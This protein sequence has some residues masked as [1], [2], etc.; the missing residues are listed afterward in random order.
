MSG[1]THP[2]L[3]SSTESVGPPSVTRDDVHR[4]T[5]TTSNGGGAAASNG[6]VDM[7][8]E[9]MPDL[10]SPH[11]SP[12]SD[13]ILDPSKFIDDSY[14]SIQ[15]SSRRL[16][17]DTRGYSI[18]LMI[19]LNFLSSASFSIVLPSMWSYLTVQFNQSIS[20]VGWAVC[21]NSLG[22]FL[23]SPLMSFWYERR[24]A[25]E[26]LAFSLAAMMLG[27]VMYAVAGNPAVILVSRALVG[28]SSA[29][30]TIV[31]N[32]LFLAT[33]SSDR[34][35]IM[36]YNSAAN[37]LGFTFGPILA[38]TL[39]LLP[40]ITLAPGAEIN[41][42]TNPGYCIAILSTIALVLVLA[43]LRE[44]PKSLRKALS[45]MIRDSPPN[46]D[47]SVHRRPLTD[48][49]LYNGS[50]YFGTGGSI[51]D[52][53]SLSKAGR[54]C[55]IP[56]LLCLFFYYAL[57]SAFTVWE[58]LGASFTSMTYNFHVF[59]NGLFFAGMGFASIAA[60]ILM[61]LTAKLANDRVLL[62]TSLSCT[63]IG[64]G[65][66]MIDHGTPPQ[67][68]FYFGAIITSVGYAMS[69]ALVISVYNKFLMVPDLSWLSAS[70]AIARIIGP[71]TAA[72]TLQYGGA[73][74]LWA[75]AT[76][77]VASASLLAVAFYR[78]LSPLMIAGSAEWR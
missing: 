31:Q 29:N 37:M 28:L 49:L 11:Y 71:V 5:H 14:V 67:T 58:T 70:G 17:A 72:Y 18:Y 50:G 34:T 25:R 76:V 74:L 40:V 21:L 15:A 64:F 56:M 43:T 51:E 45:G 46:S 53:V 73:L 68:A 42:N 8:I 20:V 19:F 59:Y 35:K 27:N 65:L 9:S 26:V 55:S 60:L 4:A 33:Q 57:T 32:Y 3:G 63:S 41:T 24:T 75:M 44:I 66:M 2:L 36:A 22:S 39:S 48:S 30:Y 1:E 52:V 61:Q 13:P 77:L 10:S 7:S 38:S 12:L 69:V 62:A 54:Q 78:K 47:H 6:Y 23:G 16:L